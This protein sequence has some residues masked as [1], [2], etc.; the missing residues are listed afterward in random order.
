[1]VERAVMA[2]NIP[3]VD[4]DRDSNLRA[5]PGYFRDEVLRMLLHPLSL[6]LLRAT[7]SSQFSVSSAWTGSRFG[8]C[9]LLTFCPDY[10]PGNDCAIS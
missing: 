1:L 7:V 8:M 2:P 9:E 4:A 5:A 6:S 10:N 3:K